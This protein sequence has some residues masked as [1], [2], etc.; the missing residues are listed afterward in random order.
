MF[1]QFSSIAMPFFKKKEITQSDGIYPHSSIFF[2][3]SFQAIQMNSIDGR[4]IF[5]WF[6]CLS[7]SLLAR[8]FLC[9]QGN[10][11]FLW[12]RTER[13]LRF[14]VCL[15]DKLSE[16]DALEISIYGHMYF[17]TTIDLKKENTQC[18]ALLFSAQN[19]REKK[20][21]ELRKK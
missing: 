5:L 11:H 7:F 9:M 12:E 3:L 1:P 6:F 20:N 4:A 8:D 13:E 16:M 21:W 2:T 17:L 10:E 18:A 19:C 14:I 15:I